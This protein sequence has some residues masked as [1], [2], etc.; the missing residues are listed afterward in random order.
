M[1]WQSNKNDP[2]PTGADDFLPVLIFIVLKTKPKNPY[3]ICRIYKVIYWYLSSI[4]LK[5]KNFYNKMKRFSIT[6]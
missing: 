1:V 3:S 2:T 5:L 4:V 6:K